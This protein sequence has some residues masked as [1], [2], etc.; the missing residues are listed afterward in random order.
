MP[1]NTE[2]KSRYYGD[3]L[4]LLSYIERID[5]EIEQRRKREFREGN[6]KG[7][8]EENSNKGN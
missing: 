6:G 7:K 8:S 3:L 5:K 1:E 4:V 2:A